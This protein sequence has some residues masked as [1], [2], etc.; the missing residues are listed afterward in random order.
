[1]TRWC[2]RTQ[3]ARAREAR[4]AYVARQ[5]AWLAAAGVDRQPDVLVVVRRRLGGQWLDHT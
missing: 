5:V 2:G 3:E 4:D 1:M